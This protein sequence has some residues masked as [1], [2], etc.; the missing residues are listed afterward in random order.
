MQIILDFLE[1]IRICRMIRRRLRKNVRRLR[2]QVAFLQSK[3][4]QAEIDLAMLKESTKDEIDELEIENETLKDDL[5]A[6]ER[7]RD[8]LLAEADIQERRVQ[9]LA[10]VLKRDQLRVQAEMAIYTQLIEGNRGVL[11][12]GL[13]ASRVLMPGN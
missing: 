4:D 13:E 11:N 2:G 6:V 7:K 3:L 9:M 12:P 1:R 8:Q 10:D 5:I